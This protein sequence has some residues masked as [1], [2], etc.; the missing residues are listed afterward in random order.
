MFT[1]RYSGPDRSGIC[2]CGHAWNRHHLGMV[3]NVAYANDTREEYV[4]QEC[5]AYGFNEAGGLKF[6]GEEWVD[7]CRS[8]QDTGTYRDSELRRT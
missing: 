8:Y 2:T 3:M 7:H 4:P 5:E 6:D 1:P